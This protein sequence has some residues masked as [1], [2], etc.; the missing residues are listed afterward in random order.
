MEKLWKRS[1]KLSAYER[2]NWLSGVFGMI[3][4]RGI[5]NDLIDQLEDDLKRYEKE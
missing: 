3:Q 4:G 5:P 2:E 1:R